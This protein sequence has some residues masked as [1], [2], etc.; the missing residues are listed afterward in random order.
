MQYLNK[1]K[2]NIVVKILQIRK[3]WNL[4]DSWILTSFNVQNKLNKD[5]SMSQEIGAC[6][7]SAWPYIQNP[8]LPNK[9]INI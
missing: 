8:H 3:I 2:E 7:R 6:L 9:E 4:R 1:L 5:D